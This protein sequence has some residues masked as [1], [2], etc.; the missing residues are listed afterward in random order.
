M[1]YAHESIFLTREQSEAL[2][3][4][5]AEKILSSDNRYF[6]RERIGHDP[7]YL[8]LQIQFHRH[9]MPQFL[10]EHNLKDDSFLYTY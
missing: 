5:V 9:G 8:D 1:I 3:K 10:A 2:R 7:E 4:E 6:A